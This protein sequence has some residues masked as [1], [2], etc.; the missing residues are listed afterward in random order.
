MDVGLGEEEEELFFSAEERTTLAALYDDWRRTDKVYELTRRYPRHL[1]YEINNIIER[2]H[3][4]HLAA[5]RQTTSHP[6]ADVAEEEEEE[7][8]G[9]K[10][11]EKK[12][13]K[14]E[15]GDGHKKETVNY[16]ISASYYTLKMHSEL[17]Q[18]RVPGASAFVRDFLAIATSAT[19]SNDDSGHRPS[20]T[21]SSN[22]GGPGWKFEYGRIQQFVRGAVVERLNRRYGDG[23]A[24]ISETKEEKTGK[25]KEKDQPS[26]PVL[27]SV[28]QMVLKNAQLSPNGQQWG[29]PLEHGEFLYQ[30]HGVRNIGFASLLNFQLAQH[31]DVG[32]C[33][34]DYPVDERLR[35]YG[36]FWDVDMS[37]QPGNWFLNP[38]FIES[39]MLR[40]A[41][42]IKTWVASIP[43]TRRE[44]ER[45]T[46][47]HSARS[48]E[49]ANEA[50][51]E[52]EEEEAS[53]IASKNMIVYEDDKSKG[54]GSD[55]VNPIQQI[56]CLVPNWEDA[57]FMTVLNSLGDHMLFS[58]VL[59]PRTYRLSKPDGET[60]VAS[61]A[62]RYM[63]FSRNRCEEIATLA[64]TALLRHC[65]VDSK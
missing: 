13:E 60:F 42:T 45:T 41:T 48:L 23:G 56:H 44:G 2:W 49:C 6:A 46:T 26:A 47:P 63:V 14:K 22:R 11:E 16:D 27:L 53:R 29:L 31:D 37:A 34:A 51:A 5:N 36:S 3:L 35:S 43:L 21:P 4:C 25:E 50:E 19:G 62:C 38:P 61:T 9:K 12:E 1:T 57:A 54:S 8:E 39:M 17:S 7:E 18:K 20:L 28:A 59:R 15:V 33:S 55:G 52:E 58:H 64:P 65:L 10:T 24:S 30:Q 40:M 32:F